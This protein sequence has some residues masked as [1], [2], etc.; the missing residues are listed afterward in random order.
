MYEKK[1]THNSCC[2]KKFSFYAT[3]IGA[4]E[5]Y[6]YNKSFMRIVYKV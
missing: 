3:E 5:N 4:K 2:D 1:L 6:V